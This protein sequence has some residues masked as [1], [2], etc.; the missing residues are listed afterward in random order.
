[1]RMPWCP[2]CRTEYQEGFEVCNDCNTTLIEELEP[3]TE[4][5]LEGDYAAYLMSASDEIESKILESLLEANEIPVL[6]KYKEAGSYMNIYMG[7]TVTGIDLYVPHSLLPKAQELVSDSQK[8][9]AQPVEEEQDQS[10]Q[11]DFLK[12]RR[13]K[14]WLLLAILLWSSI[15]GGIFL[16]IYY[17]GEVF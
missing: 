1:M 9:Q 4:K 8:E 16:G 7:M 3:L 12:R 17:M 10:Y 13:R 14:V 11:Q 5:V 6:K 2:K 15:L